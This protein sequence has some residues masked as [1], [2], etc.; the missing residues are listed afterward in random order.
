MKMFSFASPQAVFLQSVANL[1]LGLLSNPYILAALP[2]K[3]LSSLSRVVGHHKDCLCVSH[4]IQTVK[5]Q[6]LRSPT[7]S[8][9]S[10]LSQTIGTMWGDDPGFIYS[11]LLGAGPVLLTLLLFF[12]SSFCPSELCGELYIPFLWSGTSVSSQVAFCK[13]FC[14]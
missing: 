11:T 1:T 12:S 2:S 8:N 13:M 10:P 3:G 7:A 5:D 14:I 6:L 9:A 4:S